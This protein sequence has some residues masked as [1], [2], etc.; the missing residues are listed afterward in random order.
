MNDRI[1]KLQQW[2]I[3]HQYGAESPISVLVEIVRE[4]QQELDK[5]KE[6]VDKIDNEYRR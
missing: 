1:T 6:K 2:I 3:D 4:Q 5:L